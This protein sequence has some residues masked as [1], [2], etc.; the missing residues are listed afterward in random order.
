MRICILLLITAA[1]A[2][3]GNHFMPSFP[4]EGVVP[5]W[6][7]H[8]QLLLPKMLVSI[9][10]RNLASPDGCTQRPA[11]PQGGQYPQKLCGTTVRVAGIPAGLLAVLDSQINLEIPANAPVSG[12]APIVVTV[13]G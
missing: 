1:Q 8:A 5:V 4:R 7:K 2:Q 13:D 6:G 12:E 11:I 3:T 9:Y 10:G